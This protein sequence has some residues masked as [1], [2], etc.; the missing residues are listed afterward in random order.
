MASVKKFII[1]YSHFFTGQAVATLFGFISFPIFTR[2]LTQEQYGIMSFVATTIALV[3]AI[4][5]GGLSGGIIRFYTEY[6]ETQDQRALFASTIFF[7]G[8]IAAGVS[9]VVY[10]LV[11]QFAPHY[12]GLKDSYIPYLMIMSVCVFLQP[13][14]LIVQNVL[15]ISGKTIL[16][17]IVVVIQRGSPAILSIL[18]LLYVVGQFSGYFIGVVLGEVIVALILFTWFFSTYKINL[19]SVSRKLA[20]DLIGFG[21]PLLLSE[22][23]YLLLAYVDRYLI[24]AFQG[25]GALGVY[26]VGHNMAFYLS[27]VMM[28]PLTSSIVPLYITTYKNEGRE[29]TEAFLSKVMH[30]MLVL[31]IPAWFGYHAVARD[32]FIAV[33]SEKYQYAATFSTVILLGSFCYGM[34]SIFSAGLFLQKKT[35]QMSAILFIGFVVNISMNLLLLPKY[36]VMGAAISSLVGYIIVVALMAI[37]STRYITIKIS[38]THI[39]YYCILSCGMLLVLT[40]I[41]TGSHWLNLIVKVIC[42]I[43]FIVPGVLYKEKEVF[44]RLITIGRQGLSRFNKGASC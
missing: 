13:M 38:G 2:V 23:S 44:D 7:R 14:N 3:V 30:Y 17:N 40:Q 37:L 43:V 24:L 36:G 26:S 32:L 21:F 28:L 35:K 1:H 6:S 10:L 39:L 4:T 8:L 9:V 12:I 18:M 42:G 29:K 19:N 16:Y 41:E 31:L 34:N 33:A 11:L 25:E 15:R 27:A 20:L 22:V 5:K